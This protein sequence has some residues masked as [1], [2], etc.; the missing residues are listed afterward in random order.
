VVEN[1]SF[2]ISIID[3]IEATKPITNVCVGVSKEVA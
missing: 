2:A 3:L 1:I